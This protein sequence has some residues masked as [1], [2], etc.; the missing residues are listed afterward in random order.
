MTEKEKILDVVHVGEF[1]V[2][3]VVE[4][5]RGGDIAIRFTTAPQQSITVVRSAVPALVRVLETIKI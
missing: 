1:P 3:E 2:Y 4:L 5:E